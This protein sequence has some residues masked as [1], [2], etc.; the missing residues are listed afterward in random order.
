MREKNLVAVG[1]TDAIKL[2]EW[3]L[4]PGKRCNLLE[5][6]GRTDD[7]PEAETFLESIEHAIRSAQ[8]RETLQPRRAEVKAALAKAAEQSK[9]LL[10]ALDQIPAAGRSYFRLAG[11][12]WGTARGNAST[13]WMA[14]ERA[15]LQ[16]D[17][18]LSGRGDDHDNN[19]A[20]LAADI[21]HAL[22]QVGIKPSLTRPKFNKD[23]VESAPPFWAVT[24]LCFRQARFSYKD[25]YPHMRD[26]LK[27][28][29]IGCDD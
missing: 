20:I 24:R 9:V 29:S 14:A 25:P 19:P 27:R 7:D 26:G 10:D 2:L 18:D 16:A 15:T 17:D 23:G 5:I 4:P 1:A 21:A 28:V 13:L 6:I 22:Q 3:S 12:P 11:M 8:W